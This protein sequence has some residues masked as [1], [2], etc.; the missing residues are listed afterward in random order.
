MIQNGE[1]DHIGQTLIIDE[2]EDEPKI[3]P[4][5]PIQIE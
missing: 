4:G 1:M 5:I 2:R 3:E